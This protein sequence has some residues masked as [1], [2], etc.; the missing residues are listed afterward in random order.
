MKNAR[1]I[2]PSNAPAPDSDLDEVYYWKPD[3]V[4]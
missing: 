1:I 2:D 3:R 4:S